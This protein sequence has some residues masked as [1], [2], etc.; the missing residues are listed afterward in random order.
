MPGQPEQFQRA[1]VRRQYSEVALSTKVT[2]EDC[3]LALAEM[4]KLGSYRQF[5]PAIIDDLY[6]SLLR[7]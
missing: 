1:G 5:T 7:R 3:W 2:P 4:V 6:L